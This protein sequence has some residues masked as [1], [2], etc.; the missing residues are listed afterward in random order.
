MD[1]NMLFLEHKPYPTNTNVRDTVHKYSGYA[2]F[3]ELPQFV[4]PYF[5][6]FRLYSA[7]Y[8]TEKNPLLFKV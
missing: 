5:I 8:I 7:S 3:A 6:R 4:G 1:Q 2:K